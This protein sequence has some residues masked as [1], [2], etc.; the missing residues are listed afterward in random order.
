[1]EVR[2]NSKVATKVSAQEGPNQAR[3]YIQRAFILLSQLSCK[4]V[5][6]LSSIIVVY[7]KLNRGRVFDSYWWHI[8]LYLFNHSAVTIVTV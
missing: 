6:C 7:L 2:G 8:L 3:Q 5:R 4:L 1:M